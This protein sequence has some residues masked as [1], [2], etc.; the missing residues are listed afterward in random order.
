M[1]RGKITNRRHSSS[2]GT[3]T[4]SEG[5]I[6]LRALGGPQQHSRAQNWPREA[7]F[8][9]GVEAAR[10]YRRLQTMNP[11][12]FLAYW[13]AWATITVIPRTGWLNSRELVLTGREAEEAQGQGVGMFGCW[14]GT[15]PGLQRW[16]CVFHVFRWPLLCAGSWG[17]V[18]PV[19]S[20]LVRTLAL[21]NW[22][23]IIYDIINLHYFLE[24]PSSN[25]GI[26]G[27][28]AWAYEFG[29]GG[30]DTNIQSTNSSLNYCATDVQTQE[31]YGCLDWQRWDLVSAP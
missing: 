8:L 30:G 7:P 16:T 11:G 5:C 26:L 25:T 4:G 6:L 17:L 15:L 13:C 28:R 23:L 10:S 18:S 27:V 12:F 2:W 31:S 19:T 24:A 3:R 14:W 20:L 9:S 1:L 29:V 21:L 22:H